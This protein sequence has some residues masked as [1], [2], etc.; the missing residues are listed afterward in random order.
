MPK[1]PACH[2]LVHH[3]VVPVV[4]SCLLSSLPTYTL[5]PLLP[6]PTLSLVSVTHTNTH[7]YPNY[8]IGVWTREMVIKF[9]L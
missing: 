8:D 9:S 1:T 5:F 4:F 2:L 3:S 7:T 6:F